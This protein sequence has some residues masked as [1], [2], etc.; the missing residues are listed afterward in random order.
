MSPAAAVGLVDGTLGIV[1]LAALS[2]GVAMGLSVLFRWYAARKAPDGVAVL[3]GLAAVALLLNTTAALTSAIGEP[4]DLFQPATA[5]FTIGAFAAGTIAAD[6][7][8]RLGDR[9]ALSLFGGAGG[10][11]LADVTQLVR[12]RGRVIDVQLPDTVADIDG[13]DPVPEDEKA[14]IEGT[15]MR[16]PRRLTVADLEERIATRLREDHGIGRVDLEVTPEG[17]VEYLAVG[18]RIAGIGATLGPGS[19]AVAIRADPAYA[20]SP[21]DRVQVWT[22]D[23]E[24]ERVLTAELRAA[25]GNVAT[26][27]VDAFEADR[28]D[29]AQ[30]YRLVTLPREPSAD[31]EFASL[32]RA[33]DERM[34]A[35]RIDPDSALAGITIGAVN[36][37][38]VAI[39]P[40]DGRVEP[41]PARHRVLGG[42]ETVYVVGSPDVIRRFEAAAGAGEEGSGH[43]EAETT[44]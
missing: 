24:P 9:L 20:A 10:H 3:V 25:V 2:G 16:F 41:I 17:D 44:S 26:L 33:A 12:A 35:V 11:D 15:R 28:L 5:L 22:T 38:V 31:R 43:P 14:A 36:G 13:Y 30:S 29:T 39:R 40:P 18:T 7:G 37:T 32:L 4:G 19:V 8:N 34:A 27:A 23:P 21:G 1:G 42:G 6:L